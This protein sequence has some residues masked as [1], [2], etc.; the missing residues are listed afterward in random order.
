MDF[1]P[2]ENE[3][4]FSLLRDSSA[5]IEEIVEA[6]KLAKSTMRG[7][8]YG[9]HYDGPTSMERLQAYHDRMDML[10]RVYPRL[11]EQIMLD[12]ARAAGPARRA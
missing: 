12:A 5:S 2:V 4:T 8:I 1:T 10:M 7:H 3:T 11:P 6:T 9:E